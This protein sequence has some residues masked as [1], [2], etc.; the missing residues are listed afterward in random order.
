M[1]RARVGETVSPALLGPD[2][3]DVSILREMYRGRA[4]NLTGIDPRL[5]ANRVAGA[6][7]VGRARVAARLRAWREGGFLT[8]YA[9]WPNPAL[10]SAVGGWS[11]IRVRR[12]RA[13]SDVFRRVALVD[14]VVSGLEF[15]GDW[16]SVAMVGPD[17]GTLRRRLDVIR[18][19][20]DVVEAEGPSLW[21]VRPPGRP[22]S[23]L[24]LRILGAL[25]ATPMGS[26]GAIAHRVGIS[27]RTM[28]RKYS[29]LIDDQAVWF[30]P[31][32]DFRALP[33]P[34][35]SVN[36]TLKDRVSR[37]STAARIRHR[38]PL[39]LDAAFDEAGDSSRAKELFVFVTL[40]SVAGLEDLEAFVEDLEGVASRETYVLVRIHDFPDWFDRELRSLAG[41]PTHATSRA[42][43][44]RSHTTAA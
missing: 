3:L 35:V 21:S 36:L 6:L 33:Y 44:P 24:D 25:R 9:V 20:A 15:L 40:P 32:F 14:G 38:Y 22:L 42:G 2:A 8:K 39:T 16:I 18:N 26:L 10:L 28:T 1:R 41:P 5:N 27:T 34:V 31:V 43:P 11:A 12:P 19:L 4:V 37:E 23:P 13:K 29:A 7:G 17:E 30:V